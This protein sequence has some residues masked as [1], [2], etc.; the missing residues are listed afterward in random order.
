MNLIE[1]VPAHSWEHKREIKRMTAYDRHSRTGIV[2][3][4]KTWQIVLLMA[5]VAALCAYAF[6]RWWLCV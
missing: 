3:P 6:V 5:G 2:Q 1:I 4:D